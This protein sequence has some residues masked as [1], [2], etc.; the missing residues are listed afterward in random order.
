VSRL[1]RG[2][3]LRT[4]CLVALLQ[5]K[6]RARQR[7][8]RGLRRASGRRELHG[9][10]AGRRLRLTA[11]CRCRLL[12]LGLQCVQRRFGL[13]RQLLPHGLELLRGRRLCRPQLCV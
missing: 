12:V 11:Q 7:R 8:L 10:L 4:Q 1:C 6:L 13:G 2:A 3:R 9:G 5:L